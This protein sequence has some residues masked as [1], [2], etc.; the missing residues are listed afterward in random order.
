MV[1]TR[2]K[3]VGWKPYLSY[4]AQ[5]ISYIS[6]QERAVLMDLENIISTLIRGATIYQLLICW[7]QG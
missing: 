5:S 2:I 1:K 3:K 6:N 4:W 7:L